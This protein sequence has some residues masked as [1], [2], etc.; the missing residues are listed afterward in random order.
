LSG[1]DE[2]RR[3]IMTPTLHYPPLTDELL[4]HIVQ[5]IRSVG[6]PHNI[7]LF[8]S[9]ARGDARPDSDLDLLWQP[10]KNRRIDCWRAQIHWRRN[11]GRAYNC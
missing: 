1:G 3:N 7:V 6:S 8:G 2:R 11:V 5:R 9:R 10:I 4:Q